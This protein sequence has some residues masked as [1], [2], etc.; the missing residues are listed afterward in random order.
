MLISHMW[1]THGQRNVK[2]ELEFAVLMI[3]MTKN[4]QKNIE[5]WWSKNLPFTIYYYMLKRGLLLKGCLS[6][7]C[8]SWSH[9]ALHPLVAFHSWITQYLLF[10]QEI[11]QN[12]IVLFQEIV[13]NIVV[14]FQEIVQNIV[15]LFREIV[16][17]IVVLCQEIVQN[18]VVLFQEIVQNIA[19][20]FQEIVQNIVVLFQEIVQINPVVSAYKLCKWWGRF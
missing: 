4:Y 13:K 15:M 6:F 2:I 18:I 7:F 1:T 9:T 16:Q 17:N 8:K 5:I 20:L 14:L 10:F 12:I 11:V 3:M 19:V